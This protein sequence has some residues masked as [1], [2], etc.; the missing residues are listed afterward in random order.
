[1]CRQHCG[2]MC[3]PC[4]WFPARSAIFI[5]SDQS[6]TIGGGCNVV[7]HLCREPF[8]IVGL[9]RLA[10]AVMGGYPVADVLFAHRLGTNRRPAKEVR[11]PKA[12]DNVPDSCPAQ[13]T[14]KPFLVEEAGSGEAGVVVAPI[15]R[16]F[17][18][19]C[20]TIKKKSSISTVSL[21]P[22]AS[23]SSA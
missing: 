2:A 17:R 6:I 4:V 10:A 15:G 21:I 18:V 5:H 20:L 8:Q 19:L 3:G 12:R 22:S 13:A 23:V 7:R 9:E 16:W 14:R 1:M 11:V